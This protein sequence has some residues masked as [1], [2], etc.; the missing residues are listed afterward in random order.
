MSIGST[1]DILSNFIQEGFYLR[2]EYVKNSGER[3]IL[4]K[5]RTLRLDRFRD[6][7]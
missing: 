5:N 6:D 4:G 3:P 7:R 2:E 1:I